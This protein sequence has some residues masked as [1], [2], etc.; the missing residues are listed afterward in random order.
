LKEHASVASFSA[1]S[2]QLIAVGAPSPLLQGAHQAALDE[3]H[4][5]A[6]HYLISLDGIF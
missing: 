1:F 4:F 5:I 6:F 3:V 2:L